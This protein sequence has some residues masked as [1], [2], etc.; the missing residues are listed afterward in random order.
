MILG[1]TKKLTKQSKKNDHKKIG[2][3]VL[4]N[5]LKTRKV[6]KPQLFR[7]Y[8]TDTDIDQI[9]VPH[10]SCKMTAS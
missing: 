8:I 1:I 6:K 10:V 9:I 5:S 3:K 2:R 4:Q 7:I